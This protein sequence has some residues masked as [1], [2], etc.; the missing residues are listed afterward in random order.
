MTALCQVVADSTSQEATDSQ[1]IAI[2]A[3]SLV[4]ETK[5]AIAPAFH[6]DYGKLGTLPFDFENKVEGGL[7]LTLFSKIEVVGEYGYWNKDSKQAIEN[8]TYNST[9]SY[10]RL[11][12]G[13]SLPFNTPTSQIGLGFRYGQSAFDDRGS[14]DI[15]SGTNLTESFSA[16]F[17]RQNLSATWLSAVLTSMA[18]FSIA[19]R[20]PEASINHL[21]RLGVQIRWRFLRSYD[22]V[23]AE[24]DPIEVYTI[25]G[26]GRT[27]SNNTVAL[28]LFLRWYPFG[29]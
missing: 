26:Y 18:N 21:F 23:Q 13:F 17:S 27:L 10:W 9:G 24:T 2:A 22:K 16:S 19:K 29:Y 15:T 25:P 11:G 4:S 5:K 7:I 20:K 28:N 1:A 8:G 14:Y 3:D 12:A 6:I